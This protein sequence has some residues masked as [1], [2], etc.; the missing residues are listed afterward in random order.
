MKNFNIFGVLGKN[1]V[2]LGVGWGV[3]GGEGVHEKEGVG[4]LRGSNFV[5]LILPKNCTL[6]RL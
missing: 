6:Y 1:R 2:L 4:F 5:K 3:V